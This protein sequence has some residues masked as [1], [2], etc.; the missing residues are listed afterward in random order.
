MALRLYLRL[1][2]LLCS[3]GCDVVV[4]DGYVRLQPKDFLLE[5]IFV[6]LIRQPCHWAPSVVENT[7]LLF[8][9]RVAIGPFVDGKL[10]ASSKQGEHDCGW[11]DVLWST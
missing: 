1:C 5:D 9:G 7:C 6:L 4:N 2:L 11:G 8:W 10:S 3:E